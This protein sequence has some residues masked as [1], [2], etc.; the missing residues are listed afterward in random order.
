MLEEAAG[1]NP[2]G[3]HYP[4]LEFYNQGP[5]PVTFSLSVYEPVLW[6]LEILP[7]FLLIRDVV[8]LEGTEFSQEIP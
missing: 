1:Y 2:E 5:I 3:E 6:N 4:A 8:Q 7:A